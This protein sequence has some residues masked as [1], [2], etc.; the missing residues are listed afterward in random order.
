[1]KQILKVD[2]PNDYA[3]YVGA[4]LLHPLVG[5][6]HYDELT[7][8]RS[9]INSYGVYGL[10]IQRAFPKQLSYGTKTMQASDGPSLPWLQVSR[11][12]GKMTANSL[13]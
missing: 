2:S 9:S 8:F 5:I 13:N 1:M 3:R 12:E 7:S 4:P 6:I 10:F 11:V